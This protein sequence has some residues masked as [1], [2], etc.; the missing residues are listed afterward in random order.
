MPQDIQKLSEELEKK[1][2]EKKY[3]SQFDFRGNE[4]KEEKSP[5]LVEF[6]KEIEDLQE[7]LFP[8]RILDTERELEAGT[9]SK[10]EVE[11]KSEPIFKPDEEKKKSVI[12]NFIQSKSKLKRKKVKKEK[13]NINNLP[14]DIFQEKETK[15]SYFKIINRPIIF[16]AGIVML[17]Y[18]FSAV[19][20]LEKVLLNDLLPS[21]LILDIIFFIYLAKKLKTKSNS[22]ATTIKYLLIAGLLIGFFRSIFKLIWINEIWTV[23]N[24]IIETLFTAGVAIICAFLTSIFINNK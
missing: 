2:G 22:T 23:I 1:L 18:F 19:S 17:I 7:D 9:S 15:V 13:S 11:Q 14:Q 16:L 5:E 4:I 24:V 21:I 20:F 10:T 6:E 8:N 12:K 3:F